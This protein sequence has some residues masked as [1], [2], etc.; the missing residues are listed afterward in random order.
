[1]VEEEGTD[2][3]AEIWQRAS[4]AASSVLCYPEGRAALAA[5]WRSKRLT[6]S[7][8]RRAVEDFGHVCAELTLVSVDTQLAREAGALADASALRGYDATHL[9]TALAL[10]RETLFLTWDGDLALAAHS[11]G[12]AVGPPIS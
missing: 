7:G 8:H 4:T 3:A 1:M 12:L 2:I 5:A 10:G 11:R 9:A 6:A